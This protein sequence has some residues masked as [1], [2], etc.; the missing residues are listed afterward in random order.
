MIA[1]NPEKT[2][3]LILAEITAM[4]KRILESYL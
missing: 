2:G 4:D 3:S 1:E